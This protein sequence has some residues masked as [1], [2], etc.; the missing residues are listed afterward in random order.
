[1]PYVVCGAMTKQGMPCNRLAEAA[2]GRCHYHGALSTGPRTAIG[3]ARNGL[4]LKLYRIQPS[5]YKQTG[6][7]QRRREARAKRLEALRKH[8]PIR[9][10][11]AWRWKMRQLIASGLPLITLASSDD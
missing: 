6:K 1:M 9:R 5:G 10:K 11:K 2:N 7:A 8:E 4:T 3:K